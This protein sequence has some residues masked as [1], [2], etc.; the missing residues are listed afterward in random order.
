M[1]ETTSS[2][3]VI[4]LTYKLASII[5]TLYDFPASSDITTKTSIDLRKEIRNVTPLKRCRSHV[6]KIYCH[7]SIKSTFSRLSNQSFSSVNFSCCYR[8]RIIL[9]RITL[10]SQ[11]S[12]LCVFVVRKF[13]FN[14]TF[15][16]LISICI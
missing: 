2:F 7:F 8:S 3:N 10:A 4:F 13:G 5:F 11:P 16:S 15:V 6:K 9:V 14:E 1:A 12:S